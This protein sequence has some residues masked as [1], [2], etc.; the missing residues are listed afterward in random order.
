MRQETR[1]QKKLSS[2]LRQTLSGLVDAELRPGPGILVT[3]TRVEVAADLKSARVG[4]SVFGPE[5]PAEIA[6][7]VAA[8]AGAIRRRL[9]SMVEIKYNPELFFEIDPSASEAERLDRI[10]ESAKREDGETR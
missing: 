6:A 2:L 8:R 4:L 5:D 7:R 3:V 10:L 1:R 9:A